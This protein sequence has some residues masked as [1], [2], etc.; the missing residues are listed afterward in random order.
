VS[1]GPQA[2]RRAPLRSGHRTGEKSSPGRG[3]LSPGSGDS[4]AVACSGAFGGLAR[5]P[6]VAELAAEAAVLGVQV[7]EA[8][9]KG[10][11]GGSGDGLHTSILG[12]AL[13]LPPQPAARSLL[14]RSAARA[15]LTGAGQADGKF[16]RF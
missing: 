16:S 14:C 12:E 3:G 2:I 8:C 10:L 15:I 5:V 11:A 6:R 9:M 4:T 7:A 1:P 13:A